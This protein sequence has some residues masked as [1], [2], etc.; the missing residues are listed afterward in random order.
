MLVLIFISNSI[1][2]STNN[3]I[4]T[5]VQDRESIRTVIIQRGGF[6]F[7]DGV[8]GVPPH[9]PASNSLGT[10]IRGG[11]IQGERRVKSRI[12][13]A[14]HQAE[15][16]FDSFLYI[17]IYSVIFQEGGIRFKADAL[18]SSPHHPASNRGTHYMIYLRAYTRSSS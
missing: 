9:N 13:S 11:P 17:Y 15:I 16:L 7:K 10:T 8:F 1:K 5:N 6:R 3:H 12:K 4:D 14:R 2:V 18:D